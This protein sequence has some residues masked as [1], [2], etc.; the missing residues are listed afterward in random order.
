MT[1]PWLL[2]AL[3]TVL[4]SLG[5]CGDDGGGSAG[6]SDGSGGGS[7]TADDAPGSGGSSAATCG[8]E[9]GSPE[10]TCTED[11][12]EAWTDCQNDGCVNLAK[13]CYG[14]GFED[15]DLSGGQCAEYTE[16]VLAC[17]SGC[18]TDQDCVADCSPLFE[19]DCAGCVAGYSACIQGR[20]DDCPAPACATP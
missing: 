12:L 10:S 14:D 4:G 2:F 17:T 3:I 15:G 11:E 20:Q 13:Q 8:G 19:G 7:G 1:R 18:D 5:A 16:C 9:G 6:G